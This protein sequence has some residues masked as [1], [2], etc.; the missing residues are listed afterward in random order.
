MPC[1]AGDC[2]QWRPGAEPGGDAVR[3]TGPW[4]GDTY[5]PT[6]YETDVGSMNV[7]R[8]S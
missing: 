1:A 4:P 8:K 7:S 6:T 3:A 2:F 5:G